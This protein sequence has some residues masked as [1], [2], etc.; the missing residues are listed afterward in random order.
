MRVL[1]CCLSNFYVD[2]FNYQENLLVR[3]HVKA[4]HE[5]LVLAS[6]EL[7]DLNGNLTYLS[8][9]NYI[10]ADGAEVVRIRYRR[11]RPYFLAKKLRAYHKTYEHIDKFNPDVILFHGTCA[12]EL[13]TFCLY[14]Q[15]NPSVKLYLDSHE[16][17]NNSAR[18]F[19]SKNILYRLFYAPIIRRSLP[20]IEK[21]LC[22]SI[23]SLDFMHKFI[24][25]PVNKL[26]YFPLGGHIYNDMDYFR[27]RSFIRKK[28]GIPTD[29]LVL[30]QSGKF[31]AK[32]KLIDS[33]IAFQ[34]IQC[35]K[36]IYFLVAGSLHE[37]IRAQVEE[38]IVKDSRIRFLG[39]MNSDDLM[40]T[41]C[42]ADVYVQPG[43]QSAT[44]QNSICCRCVVV[45]DD[46]PSHYPFVE[47]NGWMVGNTDSLINSFESA[48]RAF[49]L[50]HLDQMKDKSLSIARQLLDYKKMALRLVSNS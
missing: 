43:S 1:H 36:H 32:K 21:I 9:S 46:V 49:Q 28:L 30:L 2:N 27:N 37:S 5:V 22:V 24:G 10:G 20:Y 12:W 45:V 19:M 42:A 23:E 11:I 33:L 48:I 3:E 40:Q 7:V 26:E 18:C 38:L 6:T 39:W 17:F 4:G 25:C 47:G 16:D 44:L 50:G 34:S 35:S 13:L 8:P 31:D 41:L 15:N 29:S 14:K